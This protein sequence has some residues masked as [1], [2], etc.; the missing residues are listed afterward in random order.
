MDNIK[1]VVNGALGKMGT[2]VLNTVVRT[3]GME[4]FG[5]CDVMATPGQFQLPDGAGSVPL[6]NLIADVVTGADVVVDF[7][8]ADGAQGVLRAA[9]PEKVNVVI[10]STGLVDTHIAEAEALANEHGVGIFIAPNFAMGAVLMI[11]LAKEAARF[12]DYV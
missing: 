10:G 1:V 2:E 8:N 7:T 5:A 6:S 11:H 4:A 12:F 3:S 9:A